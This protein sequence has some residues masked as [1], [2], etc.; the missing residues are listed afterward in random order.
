MLTP[1]AQALIQ[2]TLEPGESL[3]NLASWAD[4]IRS[5]RK[6]TGSWHY[7]N[8]PLDSTGLDRK[9]DCPE[10]QCVIAKIEEF[11]T[12]WQDPNLSPAE[13]REALLFL[14]HFVGDLHQPLHAGDH[15]DK[16]GNDVAVVFEGNQTNLHSLWDTRI[17]QAMPPEDKLLPM[18]EQAITPQEAAEWSQG[19]PAQWAGESWREAQEDVY[20]P[21]P[22]VPAG[23]PEQIDQSY[24]GMAEPIIDLQLEKAGVRLAAILNGTAQ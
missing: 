24:E 2:A 1:A 22:A 14:V 21:L 23:Q 3:E 16:G 11:R 4:D 19:T 17:L 7:V 8:I 10:N 9:R 13:R 6:E 12:K 15:N 18:L 20:A 5:T